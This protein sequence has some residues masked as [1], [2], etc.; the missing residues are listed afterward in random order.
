[1][2]ISTEKRIAAGVKMFLKNDKKLS[3]N[4]IAKMN[5]ITRNHLYYA[6]ALKKGQKFFLELNYYVPKN[7]TCV[8]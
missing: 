8:F 6:M 7:K 3:Q 5:K 2:S 4:E 1:M